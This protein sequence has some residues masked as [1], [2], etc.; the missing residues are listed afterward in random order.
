MMEKIKAF[1]DKYFSKFVSRKLL[2]FAVCTLLV[3]FG[4]QIPTEWVAIALAYMG[5]EGIK[6]AIVAHN[7]TVGSSSSS[8]TTTTTNV[9]TKSVEPKSTEEV[10]PMEDQ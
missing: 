8:D 1:M 6:D 2:V 7:Q 3:C 9:T 4:I 10:K 5:V